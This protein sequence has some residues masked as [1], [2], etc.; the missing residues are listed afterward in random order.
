MMQDGG[1]GGS[2]DVLAEDRRMVKAA[3]HKQYIDNQYEE[4]GE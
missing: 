1:A 2:L 3:L 4:D